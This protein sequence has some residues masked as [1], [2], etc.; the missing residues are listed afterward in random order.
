MAVGL[1]AKQN[2]AMMQGK[3]T[4]VKSLK[5]FVSTAAKSTTRANTFS[6]PANSNGL[7]SPTR[8]GIGAQR[9]KVGTGQHLNAFAFNSNTMS[10]ERNSMNSRAF[11]SSDF[12]MPNFGHVHQSNNKANGWQVALASMAALNALAPT[13]TD[14][15][16]SGKTEKTSS[17]DKSNDLA[18]SN[19]NLD[20]NKFHMSNILKSADSLGE[21][22][23]IENMANKKLEELN[24]DYKGTGE[25]M[26]GV[27]N[28]ALENPGVQNGLELAG[29]S[30]FNTNK[31]ALSDLNVNPQDLST[32]DTALETINKDIEKF[33]GFIK[34]DINDAS[35]KLGEKKQEIS[36]G[37]Q[38]CEAQIGSLKSQIASATEES[39][40]SKSQLEADLKE[41]EAQLQELK[42]KQTQIAAAE[43]A[44]NDVKTQADAVVRELHSKQNTI[45]DIKQVKSQI[46]DKKYD[47]AKNDDSTI[48]KNKSKM[49]KL[50]KE[51]LALKEKAGG[52]DTKAQAKFE[53]KVG[54]YNDLAQ[55]M[56]SLYQSI[57][58]LGGD[59]TVTNSKGKQYTVINTSENSNYTQ[60]I[61]A[62]QVKTK[63]QI[64]EEAINKMREISETF[65]PP[66]QE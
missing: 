20:S 18:N 10:A 25:T 61:Q 37:I 30:N 43:T 62:D 27:M 17:T 52:G 63:S 48:E 34:T 42:T 58:S 40:P 1:N 19:I 4:Q 50:Q 64:N 2:I 60:E 11:F 44:I 3:Q 54:E 56:K 55:Q 15:V 21:V 14:L 23:K 7:Y 8:F 28:K 36:T 9:S 6:K 65:V 66:E 35:T 59:T 45:G 47:T 46:A 53:S 12:G 26:I 33:E 24:A 51:I 16:N 29:L 41:Q 49:D 39:V 32:L 5:E 57:A 22:T 38:T 13:I 31:L